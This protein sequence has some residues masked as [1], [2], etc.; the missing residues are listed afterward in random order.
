MINARG[1][2]VLAC[3]AA[4]AAGFCY[5]ERKERGRWNDWTATNAA[6]ESKGDRK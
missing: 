6:W 4:F 1:W 5:G 2:V 3:L